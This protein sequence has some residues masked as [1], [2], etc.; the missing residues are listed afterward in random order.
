[1]SLKIRGTKESKYFL[2]IL[3]FA[4]LI[5]ICN[6]LYSTRSSLTY[7]LVVFELTVLVLCLMRKHTTDYLIFYTIF[8]STALEFTQWSGYETLYSVKTIRIL[9]MNLGIWLLLPAWLFL[10]LRP[11]KIAKLKNEYPILY[12]FGNGLIAINIIAASVGLL[13]IA[14]NDNDIQHMM[15]YFSSYIGQAYSVMLLSISFYIIFIEIVTFEEKDKWKISVALQAILWSCVIQM[16]SSLKF[17]MT[18]RYGNETTILVCTMYFFLPFLIVLP[19]INKRVP[20]S[21]ANYI[22]S[23]IGIYLAIRYN[24]TGKI[25][26][27]LLLVILIIYAKYYKSRKMSEKM[28]ANILFVLVIVAVVLAV[29]QFYNSTGMSGAK[30]RAAIELI[31]FWHVNWFQSL[32]Y[33]PRCRVAE[34][35]NLFIEYGKKPW[36]IITGKG[37]LGTIKDYIGMFGDRTI[38]TASFSDPEWINGTFYNLHEVSSTLLMY[39]LLGVIYSVKL[40]ITTYKKFYGN[41]FLLIGVYWFVLL[42]GYSFTLSV[43]GV[44]CLMLGLAD[45]TAAFKD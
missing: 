22:V 3:P 24:A 35:I 34:F 12:K 37:F 15:G 20:F 39:G 27:T 9:G 42:Y 30:L 6:T 38:N 1:M 33:S 28:L 2:K 25:Y 44:T 41:C 45:C 8:L 14:F 26:I 13:L 18:G 10:F 29:A 16:I 11:L 32:Q 31:S 7:L 23:L 17:G 21:G 19:I 5:A 40:L 43:F 4:A 36:L